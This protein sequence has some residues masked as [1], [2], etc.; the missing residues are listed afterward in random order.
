VYLPRPLRTHFVRRYDEFSWRAN[1]LFDAIA[2]GRIAVTVGERYAL[3][4]AAQTHRDLEG[5]KTHGSTVLT[6]PEGD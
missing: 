1:E 6:P 2:A 4:D 5:R 3:K